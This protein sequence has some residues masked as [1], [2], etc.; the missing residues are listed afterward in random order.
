MREARESWNTRETKARWD[1]LAKHYGLVE[2]I[3]EWYLKHFRKILWAHAA[4]RVLEAGAGSGLNI[5]FYPPGA[6]VTATDLSGAMM[7]RARERSREQKADVTFEEA[8]LCALPFSDRTFDTAVATFVF[9]SVADPVTCLRELARVVKPTGKIL[10][11][12]HVRI[13]RPL[14][15]P[16]MDRL[17]PATVRLAGEHINHRMD[18]FVR[19]AGLEVVES[20]RLGF[21]GIMQFIVARPGSVTS[22]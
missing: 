10:L 1:R 16:F 8:D 22:S 6:R 11:L 20:R 15:G 7:Q 21:M 2:W 13:E 12:D 17:N 5:A 14:I 18:A 9:C 4:G 3:S 19:S